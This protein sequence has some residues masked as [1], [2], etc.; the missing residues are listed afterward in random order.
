LWILQF[1]I[2]ILTHSMCKISFQFFDKEYWILS[3]EMG[4]CGQGM[5]DKWTKARNNWKK[6]NPK[7]VKKNKLKSQEKVE[8]VEKEKIYREKRVWLFSLFIPW[9]C[10]A[11]IKRVECLSILITVIINRDTPVSLLGFCWSSHEL[12][13][14][15]TLFP[16]H[17]TTTPRPSALFPLGFWADG[18]IGGGLGW[19]A[20]SHREG[21]QR[22]AIPSLWTYNML[23]M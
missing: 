22:E 4:S 5:A 12:E 17:H 2:E 6:E 19:A 21:Q 16:S 3:V 10:C 9:A 1:S 14:G 7:K 8:K 20:G 13:K 23:H 11:S 15:F 18:E